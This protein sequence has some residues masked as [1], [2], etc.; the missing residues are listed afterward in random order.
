MPQGID[1]YHVVFSVVFRWL[2]N[3]FTP[4]IVSVKKDSEVTIPQ[5][6]FRQ[7]Q[8]VSFQFIPGIS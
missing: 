7:F 3:E 1:P 4:V 5:T 8:M 6:S 2:N